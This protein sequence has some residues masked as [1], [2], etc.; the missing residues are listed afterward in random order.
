MIVMIPIEVRRI[1]EVIEKDRRKRVAEIRRANRNEIKRILKEGEKKCEDVK[2]NILAEY[3][4]RAEALRRKGFAEIEM[5]RRERLKHIKSEM[6]EILKKEAVE[7][8]KE[9]GYE[10]F[11]AKSLEKGIE[12]MGGGVEVFVRKEDVGF[13][14]D[15][16]RKKGV[17]GKIKTIKTEGGCMIKSGKITVNYLIESILERKEVEINKVI[18]EIFFKC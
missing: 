15:F 17:R 6:V 14:E 2:R 7:R 11:L 5:K 4:R 3:E 13:V 9:R 18:N 10:K 1:I 16:L 8:I 12:E